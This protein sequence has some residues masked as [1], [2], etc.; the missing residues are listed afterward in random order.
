MW[1]VPHFWALLLNHG[2]EY[3]EAGLPSLSGVFSRIQLVRIISHWIFA[4]MVSCLFVFLYGFI[5][6]RLTIFS[7]LAASLWFVWQGI[8]LIRGSGV[9]EKLNYAIFKRINYYM[10]IVISLLSLDRM[11]DTLTGYGLKIFMKL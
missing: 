9:T 7:L 8:A 3:E 10:L 2:K 1:Q 11:T 6:S 5:H 4:T